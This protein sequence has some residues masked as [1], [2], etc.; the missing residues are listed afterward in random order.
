MELGA[1]YFNK[2]SW[3]PGDTLE[4]TNKKNI[5]MET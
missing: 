5:W 3:K 2:E 1:Q 4:G